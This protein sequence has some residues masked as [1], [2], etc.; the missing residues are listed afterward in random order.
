MTNTE[1]TH[2]KLLDTYEQPE[3]FKRVLEEA[4]ATAEKRGAER[5]RKEIETRMPNHDAIQEYLQNTKKQSECNHDFYEIEYHP[6]GH[7][8]QCFGCLFTK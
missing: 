6:E 7:T 4:L 5:E 8:H 2:L 1:E 3:E